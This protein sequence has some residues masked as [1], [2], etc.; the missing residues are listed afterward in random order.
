MKKC[1]KITILKPL[2]LLLVLFSLCGCA[3]IPVQEQGQLARA[4]MQVSPLPA[5]SHMD[6]LAGLLEPGV[7]GSGGAAST[8]CSSCK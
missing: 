3:V 8:S 4:D 5:S 2:A 1:Q 7:L 6:R